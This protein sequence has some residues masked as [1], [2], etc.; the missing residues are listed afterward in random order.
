MKKRFAIGFLVLAML[1]MSGCEKVI[2]LTDE[3]N[4]LIAE[5]AAER[6]MK[7]NKLQDLKYDPDAAS[8]TDATTVASTEATTEASTTEVTTEA[9]T[10]AS[11]TEAQATTET[12][13]G[14]KTGKEGSGSGKSAA[15]P[16]VVT[17][18]S[19]D[20]ENVSPVAATESKGYDI[21]QLIGEDK[22]SVTYAYYMVLD[23]YPSY[24]QDGM[25]IEIQAPT[26]HKL[27]VLKFD[28]ENKT[29]E[30][31]DV[32]FYSQDMDYHII[33]NDNKRAKAM[34]TILIDDLYT[35]QNTIEP[36]DREEV[37]LLFSVSE[38]VAKDIH[39]L[40]LSVK[41][42]SGKEAILQLEE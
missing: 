10:E 29:N 19:G 27:L 41:N 8:P 33:I 38:S 7:Y 14:G 9:S 4:Y 39:G 36:S 24:D 26:G 32:D 6:L 40:K 1:A 16:K 15:D 12:P 11:T 17:G 42:T 13:S 25:F 18:D 30:M 35:Y 5:Y 28:I 20:E 31:Q 3:E 22:V 21:A 37:V 34:L 2:E 23:S